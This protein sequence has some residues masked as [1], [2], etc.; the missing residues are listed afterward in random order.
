MKCYLC[1]LKCGAERAEQKGACG[2]K[3]GIR[4]AKYYPHMFEEP[5]IS[6]EKGSGTVFF[7][8]CS[9]KCVFCQNYALSRSERGKEISP[10]RLAEIFKELENAGVHNV[11]L[12]TPTHF[13]PK[14]CEAFEIY[15]PKIPIVY[16]THAYEEISALETIDKYVDVYLPDMKFYDPS[17][18]E[19][20]T[21]KKNYFEKAADA[22]LFMMN[23]KKAV[24]SDGLMKSG[25]I[26]R[27]MVMPLCVPD[28]K[29]I[30]SWFAANKKNGAYF[31]L[32]AQYTPVVRSDKYP[33]L[34]RG[35][36][37]GEYERAYEE[38]LKSGIT[39]Y[40]IQEL[41]SAKESFIPTW[42]Y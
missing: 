32:M 17:L 20:Y 34:N 4:I 7:S 25:V 41:G 37:A 19:R 28:T 36:T 15:R 14:I 35:I 23:S 2:E 27:H 22:I 26:V 18:S 8:G 9:L 38:L 39:D 1:P 30:I 31:S 3:E 5:V 11:N 29:R 16:N 13:I 24:F 10:R 21:G 40:F 33:E 12:V 42:D 6:G